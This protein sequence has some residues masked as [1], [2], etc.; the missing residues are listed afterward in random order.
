MAIQYTQP[1]GN[2]LDLLKA[3]IKAVEVEEPDPY[4]DTEGVPTIGW[5]F[6]LKTG[7]AKTAT[8]SHLIGELLGINAAKV[9]LS[10]SVSRN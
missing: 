2:F 5:G 10:G 9:G 7:K 6:A 3:F 4:L 1:T 8:L